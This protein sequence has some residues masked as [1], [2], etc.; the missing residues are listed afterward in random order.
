[1]GKKKVLTED[2]VFK[3][4]KKFTLECVHVGD[5]DQGNTEKDIIIGSN[6]YCKYEK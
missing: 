4:L 2:E 5:F 6:K 1:M 3:L